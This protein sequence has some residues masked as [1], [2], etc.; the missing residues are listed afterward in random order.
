MPSHNCPNLVGNP[1]CTTQ[2][3]TIVSLITQDLN[4]SNIL[5]GKPHAFKNDFF[6]IVFKYTY[7]IPTS[8]FQT[9]ATYLSDPEVVIKTVMSSFL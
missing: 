2:H 6:I 3:K 1:D 8:K 4:K 9:T 5:I 7:L